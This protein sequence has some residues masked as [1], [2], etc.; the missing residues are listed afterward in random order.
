MFSHFMFPQW[1][2]AS[3]SPHNTPPPQCKP[4]YGSPVWPAADAWQQLN[5][6]VAGRLVVPSPPGA[7]CHPDL[8]QYDNISCSLVVS[9]WSNTSFHALNLIS[10]D[11]NDVACLPNSTY[12]CSLDNYPRYVVPAINAQDVQ[13]AVSF[14]RETGVRLIVKGTGHDVPGR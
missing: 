12:P 3:A 6:S 8:P 14:V 7:V 2:L 9:Q 5:D 1:A 10:T 13:Q 4:T 11:Y